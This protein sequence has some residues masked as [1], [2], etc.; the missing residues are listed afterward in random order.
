MRFAIANSH[1]HTSVSSRVNPIRSDGRL[2][3][4][5]LNDIPITTVLYKI[6]ILSRLAI[7]VPGHVNPITFLEST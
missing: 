3:S 6:P 7:P 2:V 1:L 4:L 5:P